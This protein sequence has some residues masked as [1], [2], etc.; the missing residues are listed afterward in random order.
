MLNIALIFVTGFPDGT[1]KPN[2]PI[3]REEFAAII[4]RGATVIVDRALFADADQIS[5]WAQN[6][7]NTVFRAG[8]M[9]GDEHGRF[10][11]DTNITRAKAVATIS[12]RTD[13]NRTVTASLIN[14]KEDI[15]IFSD[16]TNHSE[17]YYY[18]VVDASNSY[19]YNNIGYAKVWTRVED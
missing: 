13:R 16:V 7:V 15:L 11:P 17:W 9:V 18:Y 1:F 19:W 4:A 12:R 3:T 14:A 2:N 6:F 8:W 10:N 5:D